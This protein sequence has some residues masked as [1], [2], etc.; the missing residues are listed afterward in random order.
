MFTS[1]VQKLCDDTAQELF[2]DMIVVQE[3]SEEAAERIK[4]LVM[5][6]DTCSW[7]FVFE[8]NFQD[9]IILVLNEV[10]DEERLVIY[11][12]EDKPPRGMTKHMI[13]FDE[14]Q[15]ME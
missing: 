6:F 4:E 1:E 9:E 8:G 15:F 11:Y 13:V 7:A 10:L 2:T 12:A 3:E 14:H 5:F